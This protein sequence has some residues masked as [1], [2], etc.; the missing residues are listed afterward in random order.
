MGLN[1]PNH[2]RRRPSPVWKLSP[3]QHGSN[4]LD[5]YE[6][7]A[8]TRQ[9]NHAIRVSN[10]S[11][12]PRSFHLK[13]PFYLHR[14]DQIYKENS[15]ISKKISSTNKS[16]RAS[17]SRTEAKGTRGFVLRLWNKVKCSLVRA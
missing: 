3:K 4:L 1:S 16:G 14:L 15:K 17:R 10:G 2:P 5:S 13:S 6:L 9:L 12:T 8:I 11:S 7:Q